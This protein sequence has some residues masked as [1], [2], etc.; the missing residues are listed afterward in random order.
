MTWHVAVGNKEYTAESIEQL[1]AWMR[2][3]R[4]HWNTYVY[5]SHLG[6]WMPARDISELRQMFPSTP[7]PRPVSTPSAT[8]VL[9]V[10]CGLLLVGFLFVLALV[11]STTSRRATQ[12]SAEV[13]TATTATVS[14]TSSVADDA[15]YKSGYERGKTEGIDHANSGAGMPIPL[16]MNAMADLFS[17]GASPRDVEAWKRGFKDG[18]V[19]G[20]TSVKAFKRNDSEWSQLSWDNARAG[21]KLYDYGGEHEATIQDVDRRSGLIV[22]R[23]V[24]GAV[25]PKD[26]DA[27]AAYWW[28]R[29]D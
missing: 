14:T 19:A 16:G 15:D 1:A 22:V 28:V 4:I 24:S 21:V 6:R 5:H 26:L 18:F 3:G 29:N 11:S 12:S 13:R 25:E 23:Y 20:F 27:V 7:S 17:Q 2:E 9:L 8:P 10:G